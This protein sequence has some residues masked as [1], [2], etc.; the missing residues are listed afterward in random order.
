MDRAPRTV[1]VVDDDRSVQ[2]AVREELVHRGCYVLLAS[3][4]EAAMRLLESI[5]PE[6]L[7]L[8]LQLPR[9]SGPLIAARLRMLPRRPRVIICSAVLEAPAIAAEVEADAV[10]LKP[11]VRAD[12][13][14]EVERLLDA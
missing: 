3:D 5:A 6:V 7:V 8:D 12:L 9:G 1:L 4:G 11:F 14:R 13:R 10:V 2:E